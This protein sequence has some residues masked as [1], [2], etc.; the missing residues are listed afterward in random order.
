MFEMSANVSIVLM[1]RL[2]EHGSGN[3]NA[4][5]FIP[6]ERITFLNVYCK[7]LL[8]YKHLL[9]ALMYTS[10]FSPQE[11][12]CIRKVPPP[13]QRRMVESL[14]LEARVCVSLPSLTNVRTTVQLQHDEQV[15]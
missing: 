6:R 8:G 14:L 4:M 5:V 13:V 3:D 10:Y 7:L 2:V 9:N 11:S 15:V 1:A 12:S